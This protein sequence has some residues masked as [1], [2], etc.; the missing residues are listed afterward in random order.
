M[1]TFAAKSG[2]LVTGG[3]GG[4]SRN[5]WGD[6]IPVADP[7]TV[8][9]RSGNTPGRD[10]LTMWKTQPS[11]RK[12]IS[13]AARATAGVPIHGYERVSD[14]DR[15]RAAGSALEEA[16]R[17]P[18][19]FV[20]GYRLVYNIVVDF[21]I[22]DLFC[23]ALINGRPVR[24]PP[25]LIDVDTDF[26]GNV[27]AIRMRTPSGEAFP[28]D[29]LPLAYDAG[30]R[31]ADST[32]VSPLTTLSS[33]LDEQARAVSWRSAQWREGA[34]LSGVLNQTKPNI[35][36]ERKQ[37]FAASLRAF[38]GEGE[39]AGGAPII[40]DWLDYKP[41]DPVKPI[42]AQDLLGRQ[43]TDAEVCSSYHIPPEL[44]GARP[45]TFANIAA[46]RQMLYGPTLGPL[47][48]QIDAAFNAEIVPALADRPG[49][50]SEFDREA[51]LAGSFAEAAEV[52]SKS[53]G[54]PWMT[55][56]EARAARNMS[57]LEGAD[58]LIVPKNVSEGGLAS[59][60]DTAPTGGNP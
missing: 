50:Y 53:T 56:N 60:A 23:V 24:I 2:E 37:R 3:S 38:Q 8:L 13:F 18:G 19:R 26:L 46:F 32:G 40:P 48:E 34:K 7:G 4:G 1:A 14:T 58:E 41:I 33:L 30:W 39:R 43:L 36:K 11:L 54:G 10:P 57:R 25:R 21:C 27:E 45:G 6:I 12:V 5:S 20:T 17:Q 28:L 15:R 47:M 9:S 22:Y 31:P 51:A 59:P 55:R 29:D 16:F 44:V 49:M 35:P 42:D 52:L